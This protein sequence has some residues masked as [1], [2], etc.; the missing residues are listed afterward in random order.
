MIKIEP[1]F[2]PKQKIAMKALFEK[3]NGINEILYGGA[4]GS[5]KSYL[6]CVFIL[7]MALK[8]PGTRYLIGRSKLSQLKL[9]TL[10]TLK[11]VADSFGLKQD[12]HWR[13]N[14]NS[15]IITFSN[16]SE[17]VLK[18]LFS[19][20]SDPDFDSLGSLEITAAF[21]DE[22]AQ[23]SEKGKNIVQS[24]IRYK[25]DEYD[26]EPKLFMS[27]NPSRG[28]LYNQF[29]K[30]A[31]EGTIEDYKL[32][33]QALPTDN[34]YISK[35]YISNLKKLDKV[36]RQRLLEGAWEYSDDL[37]IMEY[38]KIVE[39]L[40][41]HGP[42]EA[43][44]DGPELK[45][46]ISVDVARQGRDATVIFVM[47][48]AMTL[49]DMV[50]LDK[51]SIVETVEAINNLKK[52]YSI[53]SNSFVSVD[54]DGVG[55]GVVDLLSGCKS[56]LNNGRALNGENYLN[57]K[58]QLIAHLANKINDGELYNN[59]EFP[60]ED[61]EALLQ[62]LMVIRR[63]KIDQDGKVRFTNKAD[64]KNLLGR[65]PDYSDAL[66]Y[67]MIHFINVTFVEDFDIE[68]FY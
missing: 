36:S 58:N 15:N 30:K 62:E 8:Y 63:D 48:S 45:H 55:G 32:F 27:C 56:I 43:P 54:E 26:L 35:H 10:K 40:N 52:K 53:I 22:V 68:V 57:L 31:K 2:H 66:A 29:Y 23:V 17:I 49:V 25:L 16:N 34:P 44:E 3:N 42:T 51:S 38:D 64:I 28:W 13:F 18:D 4:A 67:M 39:F 50:K 41:T 60:L 1:E 46:Y 14:A 21:I 65:S 11:E 6:G 61:A 7:I 9:T 5:G 19:Y 59:F 24:R 47:N 37:T 33:I 12:V 20:P